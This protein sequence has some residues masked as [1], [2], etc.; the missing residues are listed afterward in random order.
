MPVADYPNFNF[1]DGDSIRL[2]GLARASSI[3]TPDGNL[4]I[5]VDGMRFRIP[6]RMTITEHNG[7]SFPE[8][9]VM[10]TGAGTETLESFG[11]AHVDNYKKYM[12]LEPSTS[13]LES[14]VASGGMRFSSRVIWICPLAMLVST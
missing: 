11:V 3:K 5:A 10:L 2:I 6:E 1:R 4:N 14:A 7:Y 8:H 9:L 13:I 12:G